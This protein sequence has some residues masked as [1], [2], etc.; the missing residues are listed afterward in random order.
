M[1]N[2]KAGHMSDMLVCS[3]FKDFS[4]IVGS[5]DSYWAD[6]IWYENSINI[7]VQLGIRGH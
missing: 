1:V 4:R 6:F 3:Q 2:S 5:T 7:S